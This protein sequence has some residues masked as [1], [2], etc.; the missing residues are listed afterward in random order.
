MR[1]S[2][3]DKEM[4]VLLL[5]YYI[6]CLQQTA[7]EFKEQYWRNINSSFNEHLNLRDLVPNYLPNAEQCHEA[8]LAMAYAL[9]N[10]SNGKESVSPIMVPPSLYLPS[11]HY[12]SL[13]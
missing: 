6:L 8:T 4:I 9:W 1:V 5:C 10:T 3:I 2:L 13:V 7:A 12:S 11:I